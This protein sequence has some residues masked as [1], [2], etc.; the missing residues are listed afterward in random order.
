MHNDQ[1]VQFDSMIDASFARKGESASY[2][3][4]NL[5]SSKQNPAK[6]SIVNSIFVPIIKISSRS[7]EILFYSVGGHWVDR[8]QIITRI[9]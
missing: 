4:Q 1:R 8:E 3:D 2:L 6:I 9:K 5:R 7:I